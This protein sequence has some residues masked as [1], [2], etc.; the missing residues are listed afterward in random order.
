MTWI[1]FNYLCAAFTFFFPI[2][3]DI[4]FFSFFSLCSNFV[5][6]LKVLQPVIYLKSFTSFLQFMPLNAPFN[7]LFA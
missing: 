1:N 7:H 6:Y 3:A 2:L 5:V 4:I